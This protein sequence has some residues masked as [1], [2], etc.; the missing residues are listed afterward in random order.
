MRIPFWTAWRE[1]EKAKALAEEVAYERRIGL[2]EWIDEYQRH[3]FNEGTVLPG[4]PPYYDSC[5]DVGDGH[6]HLLPR[7]AMPEEPR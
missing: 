3:V 4:D 5:D 1:R 2:D 7:S 6:I